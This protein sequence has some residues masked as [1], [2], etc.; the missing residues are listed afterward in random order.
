M[1]HHEQGATQNQL[2]QNQLLMQQTATALKTCGYQTHL[3]ARNCFDIIARG[4][5]TLL[6]KILTNANAFS[7]VYV[8]ELQQI[9][10]YM[11]A[12][13]L[14]VAENA[15]AILNEGVIY[16][17][18]GVSV[19]SLE[20]LKMALKH[21][22]PSMISTNAGIAIGIDGPKLK[23]LREAQGLSLQQLAFRLGVSR[24]MVARY[25]TNFT[26]MTLPRAQ[27][28]LNLFGDQIF[29]KIDVFDHR[30]R[31][32]KHVMH[33]TSSPL[34]TKYFQLGFHALNTQHAPFDILARRQ[35][36]EEHQ[37]EPIPDIIFTAVGDRHKPG[38]H[39]MAKLF[40]A[41]SLYIFHRQRPSVHEE[42]PTLSQTEFMRFHQ[43]GDLMDFLREF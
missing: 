4:P 32:A 6:I 29:H 27:R 21:R 13:P 12:S 31:D 1:E 38:L 36:P 39:D 23:Q 15:G 10:A 5:H 16:S 26:E 33:D 19:I 8:H 41:H 35:T 14:I 2:S 42:I 7:N 37:E 34:T 28:L 24:R 18:L 25:E 3:L 43:Y 40:D 9:C 22:A 30:H 11:H 17:R 20:T